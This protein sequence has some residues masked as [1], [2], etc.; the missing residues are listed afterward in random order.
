MASSQWWDRPAYS[1]KLPEELWARVSAF[2]EWTEDR[3]ADIAALSWL[4]ERERFLNQVI[5]VGLASAE[6]AYPELIRNRLHW[7]NEVPPSLNIVKGSVDT[8][9][10]RLFT[11]L[12]ALEAHTAGAPFEEREAARQRSMALDATMNSRLLL[13][14]QRKIARDGLLKGWGAAWPYVAGGKIGIRRL[15]RWQLAVDPYDARD[16]D[17]QILHAWYVAPRTK[18]LASIA[19]ASEL[20]NKAKILTAVKGMPRLDTLRGPGVRAEYSPYDWDLGGATLAAQDDALLVLHHWRLPGGQGENLPK[21]ARGRHVITVHGGGG[22]LSYDLTMTPRH[23]VLSDKEWP[24]PTFPIVWWS[25]YPSDEGID[26]TGVGHMLLPWQACVDRTVAKK[27]EHLDTLSHAKVLMAREDA[28]DTKDALAKGIA[29]VE[30]PRATFGEGAGYAIVNPPVTN[31]EE[32]QWLEWILSAS[33]NEIG[34][35]ALLAT[36]GSRLGANAPAIALVEEDYRQL[37]RLADIDTEFADFRVALGREVLH[38]ID[39]AVQHDQQFA[40]QWRDGDGLLR[41]EPWAK[42]IEARQEYIVDLE[43]V[44][45]LGRSKAGRY[46]RLIE[47]AGRVPG[48]PPELVTEAFMGSPDLQAI[49]GDTLAGFRLIQRHLNILTKPTGDYSQASGADPFVPAEMGFKMATR[50]IQ[51]ALAENANN[52]TILRL[53][54]YQ[55]QCKDRWDEERGVEMATL[56]QPSPEGMAGGSPLP[57]EMMGGPLM[58]EGMAGGSPMAGVPNG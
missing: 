10:A 54:G 19:Q 27:Q 51:R 1:E 57:A 26:G 47:W 25:P 42:L 20:P 2:E 46:S 24:R 34:I 35:N 58:P 40:A 43:Q 41:R 9:L 8:L 50:R 17:P 44:G 30:V 31:P 48:L 49:S 7:L 39:D 15:H 11:D 37:D 14:R 53:M 22:D 33:R 32:Q 45:M 3:L 56:Q 21:E 12:P 13:R 6:A 18:L 52:E 38:A 23:V 29:I 36:G 4:Y 16:G 55:Q 5:G 28:P